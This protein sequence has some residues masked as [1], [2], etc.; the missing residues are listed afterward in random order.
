MSA[1]YRTPPAPKMSDWIEM[2][3][4]SAKSSGAVKA[5]RLLPGLD[6]REIR[7]KVDVTPEVVK[8]YYEAN[9]NDYEK[10]SQIA[11]SHIVLR[12]PWS[13]PAAD[14]ACGLVAV[15]LA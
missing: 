1:K 10:T 15:Q 12:L 6:D 8:R 13:T 7:G 4:P 3:S 11:V 5:T 2:A 14:C 9:I